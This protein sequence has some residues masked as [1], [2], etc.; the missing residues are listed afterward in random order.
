MLNFIEDINKY[1]EED[2]IEVI[3]IYNHHNGETI[4]SKEFKIYWFKFGEND[5]D[6]SLCIIKNEEKFYIQ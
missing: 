1:I 4:T 5:I 2:R 3:N 6:M